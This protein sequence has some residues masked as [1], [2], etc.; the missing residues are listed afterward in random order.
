MER[1]EMLEVWH[2]NQHSFL[3]ASQPANDGKVVFFSSWNL[4]YVQ[5]VLPD[6]DK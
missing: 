5:H 6:M 4:T 3:A 2:I 1:K